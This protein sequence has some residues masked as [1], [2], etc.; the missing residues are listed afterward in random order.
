[1]TKSR[2]SVSSVGVIVMAGRMTVACVA[3]QV[4]VSALNS[5]VVKD[6]YP[7]VLR[8]SAMKDG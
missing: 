3:R 1:M 2:N 6:L 7:S 5:A 4:P 8:I